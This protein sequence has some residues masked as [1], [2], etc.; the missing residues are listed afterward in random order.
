MSAIDPGIRLN[1]PVEELL[2][3]GIRLAALVFYATALIVALVLVRPAFRDA[4]VA[5][6]VADDPVAPLTDKLRKGESVATFAARHGLALGD[7]LALNPEIDSLA[8]KRG[9]EL[10][11]G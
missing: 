8:A 1:A 9:T 6:V 2:R 7:L 3:R 4:P 11:V 10:R 5:A